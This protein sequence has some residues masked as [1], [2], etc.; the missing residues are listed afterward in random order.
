MIDAAYCRVMARYNAWQNGQ[1]AETLEPM[2]GAELTRDRGGFF[3]SILG[4][5]NHL[6]WGDLMWMAR[7]DGGE[8]PGG[9]IP[10]SPARHATLAGW[11]DERG[12]TDARILHW[13]ETLA[14]GDLDGDLAWYSGAAGQM[15]TRPM[16]ALVVHMFNH[17][18]HHR[19]QV[20]AMLTAT[21]RAAPVS[22]LPF[23]PEDA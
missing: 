22:D 12:W 9:G 2:Q 23:M 18:T 21:G 1:L 14:E 15:V 17:Q 4:T 11:R 16:A 6:L 10:D 13:A 19:G 20:H 3:G 8:A 7:F 5:V